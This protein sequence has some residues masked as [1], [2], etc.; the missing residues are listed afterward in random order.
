MRARALALLLLVPVAAAAAAPAQGT[1]ER[2][3][4]TTARALVRL[5]GE[6][7]DGIVAGDAGAI[8]AHVPPEGLRC[9]GRIVPRAKV[10]RDLRAPDSWLH[11]VFFG[12]AGAAGSR[13][14]PASLAELFREHP[15]TAIVV[16]FVP[17]RRAGPAGRPCLDYRV[18]GVTTPGAPLCFEARGGRFWL[19]DSL[20]PCG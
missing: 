9:G 8:L 10:E 7:R 18:E 5:G 6:L 14:A 4:E 15:R 17:D 11:G 1:V 19:T 3:R 12:R 20:Y 13:A 2:D 16:G